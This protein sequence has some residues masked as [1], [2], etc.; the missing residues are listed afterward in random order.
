ML[1]EMVAPG[2]VY[3]LM[4]AIGGFVR[5]LV[6]GKGVIPLPQLQQVAG[7]RHLNLGFLTPAAIGALAGYL[8]A[9]SLGVDSVVAAIAGYSFSDGLENLIE[10]WLDRGG[11]R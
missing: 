8:T 10:R 7:S 11:R 3:A 6:T 9:G 2:L 4:R 1:T 5:L